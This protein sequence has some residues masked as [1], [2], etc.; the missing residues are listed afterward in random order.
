MQYNAT[1]GVDNRVE[2]QFVFPYFHE[3]ELTLCA[4]CHARVGPVI[5]LLVMTIRTLLRVFHWLCRKQIVVQSQSDESL[6]RL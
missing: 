1:S 6:D 3:I 2:C 4:V 5:T